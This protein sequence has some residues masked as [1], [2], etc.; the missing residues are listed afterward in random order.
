[1][2]RVKEMPARLGA[3]SQEASWKKKSVSLCKEHFFRAGNNQQIVDFDVTMNF[4]EAQ[5][6]L[7]EM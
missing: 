4:K 3:M 7:L 2:F 1:M 6:I 5:K